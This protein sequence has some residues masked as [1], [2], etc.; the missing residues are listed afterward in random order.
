M[1]DVKIFAKLSVCKLLLVYLLRPI[2]DDSG[3]CIL[4]L[5]LVG[6]V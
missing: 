1:C 2:T 5:S 6:R 4:G 3:G